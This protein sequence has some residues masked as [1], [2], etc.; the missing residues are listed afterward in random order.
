MV[1][2][3]DDNCEII[4]GPLSDNFLN[5]DECE[6]NLFVFL[7]VDCKINI[8]IVLINAFKEISFFVSSSTIPYLTV[9]PNDGR[10]SPGGSMPSDDIIMAGHSRSAR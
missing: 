3:I 5:E 7:N 8:C 6:N 10:S 9:I 4:T 1:I 2:Q